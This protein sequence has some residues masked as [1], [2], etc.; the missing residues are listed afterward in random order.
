MLSNS[1]L[2]KLEVAVGKCFAKAHLNKE[3]IDIILTATDDEFYHNMNLLMDQVRSVKLWCQIEC[4]RMWG[5]S[6]MTG[7]P[8]DRTIN[9]SPYSKYAYRGY[10]T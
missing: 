2:E 3:D 7:C 8:E 6:Y 10:R 1:K 9:T 5:Q 4:Q